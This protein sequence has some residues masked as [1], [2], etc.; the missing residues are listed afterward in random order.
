MRRALRILDALRGFALIGVLLMNIVGF[1]GM[2][3]MT[4]EQMMDSPTAAADLPVA[5]VMLVVAYGKFYSIFSLLFGIGFAL[6][7]DAALRRGDERLAV[8]K[9]RL[10]VLLGFGLV[11]MY[12]WEGDILVPY[13]LMGSC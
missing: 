2:G 5:A 7:L 1:S 11:H 9:R 4:R 12:F 10:G 8:F 13:A 3:F 6:Q